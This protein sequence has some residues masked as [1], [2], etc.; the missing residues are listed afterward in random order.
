[1]LYILYTLGFYYFRYISDLGFLD[2]KDR[3]P[4]DFLLYIFMY[5]LKLGL[6]YSFD[7]SINI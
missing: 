1:M 7:K 5:S 6:F 3:S 4:A 2:P